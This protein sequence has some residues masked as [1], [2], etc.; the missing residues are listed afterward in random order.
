MHEKLI[1]LASPY[2]VSGTASEEQKQRNFEACARCA[3]ELVKHGYLVYAPILQ[4]RP[5]EQLCDVGASWED[6]K[7]Y[8]LAII[9]KCDEVHVLCIDGWRESVGVLDEIDHALKRGIPVKLHSFKELTSSVRR[10]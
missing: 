2:T 4:S 8:D 6:W 9:E 3:H 5:I 1:Y 7:A 10:S